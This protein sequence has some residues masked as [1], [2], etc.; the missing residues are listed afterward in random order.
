[1]AELRAAFLK[2]LGDPELL[3][4]ASKAR[5]VVD[6]RSGEDMTRMVESVFALPKSVHDHLRQAL[7]E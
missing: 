6:A 5:L 4:E 7:T 3:A 1:M 2:S